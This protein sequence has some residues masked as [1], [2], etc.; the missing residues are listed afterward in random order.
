MADSP[1][2]YNP[3]NIFTIKKNASDEYDSY[4]VVSFANATLVLSIGD[5]VEEITGTT[6]G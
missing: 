3:N 6:A 5:N 4:I 2:P 1:L